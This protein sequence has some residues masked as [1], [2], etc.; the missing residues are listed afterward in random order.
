MEDTSEMC[1]Y[2]GREVFYRSVTLLLISSGVLTIAS[3]SRLGVTHVIGD[4]DDDGVGD[5]IGATKTLNRGRM[6]WLRIRVG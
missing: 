2:H 6:A 4:G 5:P 3:G 1:T